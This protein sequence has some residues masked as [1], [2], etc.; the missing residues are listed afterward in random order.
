MS[1][2]CALIF[3]FMLVMQLENVLVTLSVHALIC[4]LSFMIFED[5]FLAFPH[6]IIVKHNVATELYVDVESYTSFVLPTF[7]SPHAFIYA[8][9]DAYIGTFLDGIPLH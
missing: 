6:V 7:F 3:G 4:T 5:I 2:L 9:N 8:A 1:A